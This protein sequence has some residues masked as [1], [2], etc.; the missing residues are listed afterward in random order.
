M[1]VPG[2]GDFGFDCCGESLERHVLKFGILRNSQ[3]LLVPS[4]M[5]EI[6][7]GPLR[8]LKLGCTLGQLASSLQILQACKT[9]SAR[10]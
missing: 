1:Q 10:H 7:G 5:I 6:N 3:S 8:P 2:A 9:V 4:A